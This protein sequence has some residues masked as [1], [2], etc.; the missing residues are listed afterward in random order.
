MLT[1]KRFETPKGTLFQLS[2]VVDENADFDKA[3]GALPPKIIL[4]CGGISRMNSVGVKQWIS[5]FEPRVKKGLQLIFMECS[6][7]IV[8][9]LNSVSNFAC[10]AQVLSAQLSFTC[11]ACEHH[12]VQSYK[13]DDLRPML[14]GGVQDQPCPK[15]G[16]ASEF[17][18]LPMEYLHFVTRQRPVA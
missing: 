5:Y 8:E 2:G 10:G 9:Q 6:P 4:H 14:E 15:C 13:T 12:F 16:Q 3:L 7:V 17:D 18:D 1:A 11:G